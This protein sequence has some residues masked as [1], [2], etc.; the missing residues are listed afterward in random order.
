MP[1]TQDDDFDP[2]E[3]IADEFDFEDFDPL[4]QP[5]S[6]IQELVE[7][8]AASLPPITAAAPSNA[9]LWAEMNTA[10]TG[11]QNRIKELMESDPV[12]SKFKNKNY[13]I[14]VNA[15]PVMKAK[16]GTGKVFQAI[17]DHILTQSGAVKSQTEIRGYVAKR[18]PS[19]SVPK[20][21]TKPL[22]PWA[23]KKIKE[24]IRNSAAPM[25][26]IRLPKGV[27]LSQLHK[28]AGA[29]MERYKTGVQSFRPVVEVS[30]TSVVINGTP[31]PIST[32]KGKNGI[33]EYKQLRISSISSLLQ[34]LNSDTRTVGLSIEKHA[35]TKA[36]SSSAMSLP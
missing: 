19:H 34:A 2:A 11:V 25:S 30:D 31:F 1:S 29:A 17:I 15:I 13:G 3:C 23:I 4:P 35:S 24:R 16:E 10:K 14:Q 26:S 21:W 28:S 27:T 36:S 20:D 12:L 9:A 32:N 7:S 33:Y 6:P 8:V 18:F 22:A 5:A